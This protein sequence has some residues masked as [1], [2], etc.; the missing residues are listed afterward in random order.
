MY[1]GTKKG[2]EEI[3]DLFLVFDKSCA[4]LILQF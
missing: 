3:L 4:D 1:T 2:R